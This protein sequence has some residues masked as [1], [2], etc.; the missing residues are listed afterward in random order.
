[1]FKFNF[2]NVNNSEEKPS[3]NSVKTTVNNDVVFKDAKHV[4]CPVESYL[5]IAKKLTEC[6]VTVFL[7]NFTEISFLES[8]TIIDQL[9]DAADIVLAE[10][11]HSDLIPAVY[12]G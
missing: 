11:N 12:E 5:K 4:D 10:S 7:S 9:E 6:E 8:Q 1:M 3:E 2:G